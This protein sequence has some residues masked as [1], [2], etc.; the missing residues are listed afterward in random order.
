MTSATSDAGLITSALTPDIAVSNTSNEISVSTKA[1]RSAGIDFLRGL[2]I[3]AVVALHLHIHI[4]T[5]SQLIEHWPQ[6]LRLVIFGSGYYGVMVFLVIS[7]YLITSISLRR[8]GSLQSVRPVAFYE[9]RLARIA[10]PLLLLIGILIPLHLAGTP[11]FVIPAD[12]ASLWTVVLAAITFRINTLESAG[13]FL[14]ACWGVLWS[15]SIEETFYL[16]FPIAARF[17]RKD[18]AFSVLLGIFIVIGPIARTFWPDFDDHTYLECMDGIAF[19]CLAAVI[20]SRWSPPRR[21]GWLIFSIGVAAAL[22][23]E[24]CRGS[25]QHLGLTRNGM[26][27]TVLEF[28][29]A[30]ILFAIPQIPSTALG[31]SLS[32]PIRFAGRYSYEIYLSHGFIAIGFG[33]LFER[34]RLSSNWTVPAYLM[35]TVLCTGLGYGVAE[36]FSEPANRALRR[37]FKVH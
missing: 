16:G 11:G 3:L 36:L 37:F 14:P 31:R 24:V 21:I 35:G 9:L 1:S 15:L 2:A 17:L 23:I 30:C 32:R 4:P 18:A 20:G 8:W 22:F 34:Y 27:V 13:Y 12:K 28:G 10:P 29:T 7:G 33:A 5:K 19:G 6:H 25:V 26:Y